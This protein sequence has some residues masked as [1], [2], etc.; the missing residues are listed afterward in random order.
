MKEILTVVVVVFQVEEVVSRPRRLL[1]LW[2]VC[3]LVCTCS[4]LKMAKRKPREKKLL[5]SSYD[6]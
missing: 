2:C 3:V 5:S 1:R 4:V 6:I